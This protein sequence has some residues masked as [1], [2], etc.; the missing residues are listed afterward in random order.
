MLSTI[1]RTMTKEDIS[2]IQDNMS[3]QNIGKQ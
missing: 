3:H 1:F 2:I